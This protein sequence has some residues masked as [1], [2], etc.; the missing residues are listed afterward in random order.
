M[1]SRP[2][3]PAANASETAT[4]MG[5]SAASR[6]VNHCRYSRANRGPANAF[7][8]RESRFDCVCS[9]TLVIAPICLTARVEEV[10]L[11][12]VD[13]LR[14]EPALQ[15]LVHGPLVVRHHAL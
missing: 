13:G 10:P 15:L 7:T 3:R 4:G 14:V 6:S 2:A 1:H 12:V 8:Q 5:V 9:G 11:Q